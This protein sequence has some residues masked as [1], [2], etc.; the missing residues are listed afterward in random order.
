MKVICIDGNEA[1]V[2]QPVGVSVYTLNLLHEFKRYSSD[3][4][5]FCTYLRH[6]PQ[7]HMPRESKYFRYRVVWGPIGWNRFFL[8]L[9]LRIDYLVQRIRHIFDMR[10]IWFHSFFAPA[11][12]APPWLPPGCKLVVTI[13]DLAF[14]FFPDEFLKK[15]LYK[16]RRWTAEALHKAQHIIAVSQHTKNDIIK[17]YHIPESRIVMIPNGFRFQKPVQTHETYA[18]GHFIV[19]K[20]DYPLKSREYVLFVSTLQPRKNIK[21]LLYAFALFHKEQP[22]QHLVI[23]GKKGWM[24]EEIFQTVHKLQIDNVVHFTGYISEIDKMRLYSHALCYVLPSL[25]EGFGFPLLE[26]FAASCPVL[27]SNNSSLPEVGGDAPLYFKPDSVQE[28]L[29][30]LRLVEKDFKL[31][32]NMVD[33]GH[34]RLREYSWEKCGQQ[35]LEVLLK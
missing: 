14:H 12:Y 9:Q 19:G 20:T 32:S 21:T 22:D 25:Y 15:D 33:L 27:C 10:T 28:L 30:R 18:P 2:N 29:D 13:H 11:H 24:Y 7:L 16:L 26:A 3:E 35:T 1:N 31:S 34:A 5:R 6:H 23:V 8:P 17:Q 4:V